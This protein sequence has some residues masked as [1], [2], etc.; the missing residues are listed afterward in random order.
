MSGANNLVDALPQ[1]APSTNAPA[2]MR[3]TQR[4]SNLLKRI[5]QPGATPSAAS[6]PPSLSLLSADKRVASDTT[7][8]GVCFCTKCSSTVVVWNAQTDTTTFSS[9][10]GE[11]HTR[12]T[13][14]EVARV[15]YANN[16]G[17]VELPTAFTCGMAAK[18][19]EAW[20]ERQCIRCGGTEFSSTHPA[21]FRWSCRNCGWNSVQERWRPAEGNTLP[22]LHSFLW[23]EH[24]VTIRVDEQTV[25]YCMH[26][27]PVLL[28]PMLVAV[29]L[30]DVSRR[31][32]LASETAAS[33]AS[34]QWC[35]HRATTTTGEQFGERAI[36]PA[37]LPATLTVT[38]DGG[39]Q[40]D[41]SAVEKHDEWTVEPRVLSGAVVSVGHAMDALREK[42]LGIAAQM[43][44]HGVECSVPPC[45]AGGTHTHPLLCPEMDTPARSDLQTTLF[46]FSKIFRDG[47]V[48]CR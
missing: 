30:R 17:G 9:T 44:S 26:N 3:D 8:S 32:G 2:V 28:V 14:I 25:L 41:D 33:Y 7:T 42:I 35:A 13:H 38:E 27:T 34:L 10:Q 22:P 23:A 15:R 20:Q 43:Q 45:S 46:P 48:E 21:A 11:V 29:A 19:K 47:I 12:S 4:A 39:W 1:A 31:W 5:H 37:G 18:T 6:K 40:I 24:A 16:P 36:G